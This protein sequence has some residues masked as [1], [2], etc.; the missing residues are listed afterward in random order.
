MDFQ[1]SF[2]EPTPEQPA[3]DPFCP[4]PDGSGLRL[5]VTGHR[6][7]KIIEYNGVR[8]PVGSVYSGPSGIE[9]AVA[10]RLKNY[11]QLVLEDLWTKPEIVYIGMALGFDMAVAHACRSLTIPFM[12]CIP[13]KG[14]EAYWSDAQ[15]NHYQWL[16]SHASQVTYVCDGQYAAY[17]FLVRDQYMVDRGTH[18]LCFWN[19]SKGG[20][21]STVKMAEKKKIP[22]GNCWQPWAKFIYQDETQVPHQVRIRE[23]QAQAGESSRDWRFF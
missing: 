19:G 17:K 3:A 1:P 14:Q 12:A 4:P 11:A 9:T 16:L 13:F 6:L 7:S 23:C 10:A 5:T 22:I 2:L 20:T 8:V 18:L 15:Q 21:Y